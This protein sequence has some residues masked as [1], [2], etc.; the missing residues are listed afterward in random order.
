MSETPPTHYGRAPY[1]QPYDP[2]R[3]MKNVIEDW[4]S[5]QCSQKRSGENLWCKQHDPEAVAKRKAE[6]RRRLNE[7]LERDRRARKRRELEKEAMALLP[8]LIKECEWAD[9]PGLLAL[10]EGL[11]EGYNENR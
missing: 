10:A 4:S 1:L 11:V 2:E 5:H 7:A 6:S 9:M 8:R 3:C